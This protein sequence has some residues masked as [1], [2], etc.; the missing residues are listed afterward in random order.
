MRLYPLAVVP[1]RPPE[2]DPSAIP[3][4]AAHEQLACERLCTASAA[5]SKVLPSPTCQPGLNGWQQM[6]SNASC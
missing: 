6:G 3:S 1:E 4:A 5:L 2:D